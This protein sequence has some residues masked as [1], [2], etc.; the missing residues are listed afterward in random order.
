MKRPI[1]IWLRQRLNRLKLWILRKIGR[2]PK[3]TTT[4]NAWLYSCAVANLIDQQFRPKVSEAPMSDRIILDDFEN[5]DRYDRQK[6]A[7]L[8]IIGEIEYRIKHDKKRPEP[9][10][11]QI[12]IIYQRDAMLRLTTI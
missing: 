4:M 2:G 8:H 6:F 11:R 1:F 10:F 5:I 9:I 12:P 7:L 3:Y